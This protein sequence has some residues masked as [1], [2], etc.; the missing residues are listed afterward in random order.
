MGKE[1]SALLWSSSNN[2]VMEH[3]LFVD[4][5]NEITKRLFPVKVTTFFRMYIT[6]SDID[7]MMNMPPMLLKE[8]CLQLI[9]SGK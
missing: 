2:T 3:I 8:A 6:Y 7:V 9:L 1:I 5:M 4:D